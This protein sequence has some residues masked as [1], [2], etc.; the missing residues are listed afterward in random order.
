MVERQAASY[1]K[2]VADWVRDRQL[3]AAVLDISVGNQFR[4]QK[5][6]GTIDHV[7]GHGPA[8][9]DT[10]FDLASLTKVMATLPAVLVLANQSKL[11]FDDK[12]RAYI[13]E[14]RHDQVTI[15]H[16]LSHS[17]GLP[18]DLPYQPRSVINRNVWHEIF[19]Q[20]LIFSPGTQSLYSDLGMILLGKIVSVIAGEPLD[21][22]VNR[23][24]FRPLGMNTARFAPEEVW[25]LRAAPTEFVDGSYIKGV[26][27]DEKAFHLGGISG[28][29]GLFATADDVRRYARSWLYPSTEGFGVRSEIMEQCFVSPWQNRGLG[30]EVKTGD[31]AVSCGSQVSLGSFGHTGFTGTS[32]WIDPALELAVVFLT[33][34]VHLGRNNSIRTMRPILHHLIYSSL[35]ED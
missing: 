6:Y 13:P 16:L 31:A 5:A 11:N 27:H 33:N 25:R 19:E 4:F 17:S 34:A 23:F 3:P 18:A 32:L 12:V 2:Q 7:A 24:I 28:S 10:L 1:D 35:F 8:T 26:V 9:L 22:F 15:R 20:G 30:W 21:H 29:A 14:F